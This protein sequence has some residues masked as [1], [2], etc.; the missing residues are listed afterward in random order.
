[1]K[2]ALRVGR[3]TGIGIYLH[4]TFLLLIVGLFVF[5]LYQGNTVAAALA[6]VA[7][8]LIVFVCVIL[9]EL[10]HALTARHFGVPTKDITMYPI[11]GVARLQR[12]PDHPIEEFWIAIA[13]P[14]VNLVIAAVLGF[15]VWAQN[16]SL[17]PY[18]LV[19]PVRPMLPVLF[20]LNLILVGFNLLPAFPMDGGRV[21]RA[22]LAT[23]IEYARATEIAA[24]VGQGM[25]ILFGFVGI[26]WFNPVLLFIALFVYLGAQ[27]EARQA[28]MRSLTQG[29]SVREAMMTRFRMLAPDDTLAVAIDELLAGSEQDFPVVQ[30]GRV[31][32]V[33]TRKNLM[34]GL[35]ELGRD[36][37]V[38]D[39][40]SPNCFVIED[41]ASL[42]DAFVQMQMG[43]C[44]SVPVV[45]D[46]RIVGLLTLENVGEL[47]MVSSALRRD[48]PPLWRAR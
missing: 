29:I 14:A 25:A 37:R 47:M 18:V 26:V 10:G 40:V 20:W 16:G 39:V 12:A 19:A 36:A 17:S 38:A 42:D 4:W 44:T 11:G 7:L 6:G 2:G 32:G 34:K 21:L 5:Y 24:N 22:L 28:T 33:L 46:S 15:L 35:A 13:G 27:Q 31:V 48:M 41:T 43:E 30:E 45:R 8:V 23:R 1:M 3:V 9:H